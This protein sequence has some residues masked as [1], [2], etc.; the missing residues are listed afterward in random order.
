MLEMI[1]SQILKMSLTAGVCIVVVSMLHLVFHRIPR[2]Y[3][4][5]L[6]IVVAFRLVWSGVGQYTGGIGFDGECRA[7]RTDECDR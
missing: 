1:F 3:L 5:A 7:D 4:Y 6:W 2:K